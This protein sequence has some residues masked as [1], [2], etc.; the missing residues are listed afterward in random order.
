[1]FATNL[2]ENWFRIIVKCVNFRVP[3]K[4]AEWDFFF[5]TEFTHT[6][7]IIQIR[8][9]T[10]EKEDMWQTTNGWNTTSSKYHEFPRSMIKKT[11]V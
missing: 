9:V 6:Y 8:F 3:W 7:L 1:M 2:P 10:V 4:H 5:F 11:S